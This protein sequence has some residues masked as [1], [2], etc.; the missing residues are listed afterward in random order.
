MR[1]SAHILPYQL[2]SNLQFTYITSLQSSQDF[3]S[4]TSVQNCRN[5]TALADSHAFVMRIAS[6]NYCSQTLLHL[7]H[8]HLLVLSLPLLY[9]MQW[10]L[11]S[12][13][14]G[15]ITVYSFN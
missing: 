4:H 12:S 6:C 3:N 5:D 11:A 1:T 7:A 13:T 2:V 10:G 8:L 14:L 15:W 9:N